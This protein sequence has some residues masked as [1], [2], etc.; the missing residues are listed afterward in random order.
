MKKILLLAF[1]LITTLSYS[2]TFAFKQQEYQINCQRTEK[3][4]IINNY[5]FELPYTTT[6]IHIHGK[7]DNSTKIGA[8]TGYILLNSIAATTYFIMNDSFKDKQPTNQPIKN[9]NPTGLI[10]TTVASTA[11]L[12]IVISIY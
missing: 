9:L 8:V 4:L 7:E 2:Q 12:V 5:N 3:S 10:F 11:L 6:N 1:L